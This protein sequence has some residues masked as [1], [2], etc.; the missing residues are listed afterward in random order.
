M[1]SGPVTLKQDGSFAISLTKLPAGENTV[2]LHVEDIV[3]NASDKEVKLNVEGEQ[4]DVHITLTPSTT[5]PT[6]GPVTV[7]VDTDSTSPLVSMKWLQ[8]EK[9]VEDFANAG[10]DIDLEKSEF[11]V[12]EN[13]TYTV[14]VKNSENVEAVQTITVENIKKPAENFAITL[15]PSTVEPTEGPVTVKIETNSEADL[16]SMKWLEGKK[17]TEDFANAGNEINLEESS[18]S[19]TTNGVYTVY[20]KNS[21]GVEVVQTIE[22][23]NI[24]IPAV[25]IALTP[26]TT[27]ETEGP[28]SIKV[29]AD[30]TS[31]LVELKWLE[32]K[33]NVD[34]FHNAGNP[35]DLEAKQFDVT[36]NGTYTVYAK[37]S[38]GAEAVQT[39]TIDN[40]KVV[41]KE[42]I[43]ITTPS[44][45]NGVA[46]ISD[47]DIDRV[48]NGGTFI[49]ELGKADKVRVFLTADQIKT[50][51]E[52]QVSLII[53]NNAVEIQIPSNNL[54]DGEDIS[55]D[56]R[57][58]DDVASAD[59]AVSGVYD[60]TIYAGDKV[61]SDFGE[62]II[63]VFTV[64]NDKVKS[65]DKLNVYYYNEEMKKWELIPNA[66]HKDGKVS[67]GIN[68]FSTFAV[69]AKDP[70]KQDSVPPTNPGGQDSVPPTNP[71]G[72][73]PV[74]QPNPSGQ[75]DPKGLGTKDTFQN[76][77]KNGGELPNTATPYNNYFIIGFVLVMIGVAAVYFQYRRKRKTMM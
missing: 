35:I 31:A 42:E 33:Q 50:L 68:H 22:I 5:E 24:V 28:V 77:G 15:T 39:I 49:I 73:D 54:A 61:V 53:R 48:K 47:D 75:E 1:G 14:Y 17:A 13:G 67:V 62:P 2:T 19:V 8:G 16:V 44:I 36:E 69:F 71:G 58:V 18:F 63:L 30:S 10:N 66:V 72:Q 7:K 3:A 59:Q 45:A 76:S 9:T 37:N 27:E 56:V 23:N 11:N 64:D 46:T 55:I 12:T 65:T 60:F 43:V 34:A 38:G 29:D 6:E 41:E 25:S 70:N 20:V 51:K 74:P 40:I 52:K 57:K 4:K 21:K 32:G 26:S